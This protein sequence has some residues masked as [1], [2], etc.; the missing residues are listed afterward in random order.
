MGV[1]SNDH[2]LVAGK[3]YFADEVQVESDLY[4][5]GTQRNTNNRATDRWFLEEYFNQKPGVNAD[6]AD[7]DTEASYV[8]ANKNFEV[9]GTGA[10][11][12]DVTFAGTAG[13]GIKVE[14][15]GSDEDQVIILPHLDSNQTAWTATTFNTEDELEWNTAITTGTAITNVKIWAGLKLTNDQLIATD[16][17]QAYFYFATDADNGQALTTFANLHFVYSIG[18]T[19]YITDLGITFAALTT[20]RLRISIDSN[21]QVSVFVNDVQYGLAQTAGSTG[22]TTGGG[23]GGTGQSLALSDNV[24]L[25]PYVGIEAGAAEAK[26][27]YL[28][29]ET[30]SRNLID[31]NLT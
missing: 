2:S 7:T 12:D 8:I 30:I 3:Q 23:A 6:I 18:G 31:P 10:S 22:G 4:V 28:H 21:R 24:A 29:Y 26:H 13:T 20:Y 14:T 16:N 27:M 17:D 9:L 25:I 11:S 1:R 5:N 15:D 19:D